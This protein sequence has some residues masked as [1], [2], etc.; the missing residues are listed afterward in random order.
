VPKAKQVTLIGALSEEGFLYHELL[1]ADN[2]KAKGV[3]ADEFCL[4]L[5]SLG[6]RLPN[7]T[8]IIM[9]NAPIHQGKRFEEVKTFLQTSKSI[10]V[11]FLPPYSPFLNPI[12]YSF[13][14]IKAYVRSKEP[15]NRAALVSEIKSLSTPVSALF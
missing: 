7:D 12:E 5:G 13:H 4:F 6:A 11:E 2:T 1:N 10:P 15:P 3:G 9:D 8:V 14:S